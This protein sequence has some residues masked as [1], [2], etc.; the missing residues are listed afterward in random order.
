MIPTQQDLHKSA[1]C[2]IH[3][4]QLQTQ[5]QE[6]G[7]E[8][9]LP[10]HQWAADSPRRCF[11]HPGTTQRGDYKALPF[12]HP[13][14]SDHIT[15]MLMPAYR[16]IGK[17]TKPVHKHIQV[18]PE[19]PSETLTGI[20]LSRRPHTITK[21]TSRSTQRLSLPTSP[22]AWWCNS[23]KDHHCPGQPEAVA[24]RR[25]LQPPEGLAYCLQSWRWGGPSY[26]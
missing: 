25:G 12:P 23:P 15:V 19:G 24:N 26:S 4:S 6:W 1:H 10:A 21:Q 11:S 17:L 18:W 9:T 13:G 2:Y 3:P 5:K 14:D 8:G 7:T 20:C 22:S 16:P